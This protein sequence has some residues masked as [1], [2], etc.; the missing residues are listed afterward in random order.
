MQ[1]G[2]LETWSLRRELGPALAA[3]LLDGHARLAHL[4]TTSTL[5]S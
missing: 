1:Q 3:W 5:P 2:N 4:L